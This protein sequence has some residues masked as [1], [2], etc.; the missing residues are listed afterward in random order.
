MTGAL[1]PGTSRARDTRAVWRPAAC[2]PLLVRCKGPWRRPIGRY[3]APTT[4]RGRG[5][6]EARRTAAST[7]TGARAPNPEGDRPRRVSAPSG[8]PERERAG[9][10]T[11]P[12]RPARSGGRRVRAECRDTT[13]RRPDR[14]G[15]SRRPRCCPGCPRSRRRAL[16][17]FARRGRRQR[18]RADRRRPERPV[19]AVPDVRH[20][21]VAGWAMSSEGRQSANE[22]SDVAAARSRA[23]GKRGMTGEYA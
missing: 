5:D 2:P 15:S 7:P 6:G 19:H 11:C 22:G 16:L 3:P 8:A 13:A 4:R 21:P 9:A 23:R 1:I 17:L 14:E 18:L 20:A 10:A 12:P